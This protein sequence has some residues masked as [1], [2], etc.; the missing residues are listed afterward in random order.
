M[1]SLCERMTD[2]ELFQGVP[3]YICVFVCEGTK[4]L[5]RQEQLVHLT[6]HRC[7]LKFMFECAVVGGG[8]LINDTV[9]SCSLLLCWAR[10]LFIHLLLLPLFKEQFN[11]RRRD[12][13]SSIHYIISLDRLTVY[14]K[15]A[16][17]CI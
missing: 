13:W 15:N 2:N 16:F 5:I 1:V 11:S 7:Q 12:T 14:S 3:L 4:V 9:Y 17:V 8:M 10:A 6:F